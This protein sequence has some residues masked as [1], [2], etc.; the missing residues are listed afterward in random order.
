MAEKSRDGRGPALYG[1]LALIAL[2]GVGALVIVLAE[3]APEPPPIEAA[4]E[5]PA[6]PPAALPKPEP[7]ELEYASDGVPFK[8]HVPHEDE[9]DEP[10]HPHP[11][12]PAHERI[13]REN[14]LVH[15]MNGA[16]DV[17]DARGLRELLEEYRLE[18]PEDPHALQDGFAVIADCLD[19]PGE[20]STAAAHSYYK[21]NKAS[22]LRRYVRRYCF[23]S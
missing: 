17:G 21:A 1:P 5:K 4:M 16:M 9:P 12:T 7:L 20:L 19:R 6:P 3:R 15:S 8:P 10:M 11:I 18:Y 14:N 22:T 13:Y 2:L 23:E